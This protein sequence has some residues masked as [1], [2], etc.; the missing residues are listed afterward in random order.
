MSQQTSR[1]ARRV[2]ATTRAVPGRTDPDRLPA[3]MGQPRTRPHPSLRVGGPVR[4]LALLGAALG[5]V[6]AVGGCRLDPR[7]RPVIRGDVDPT[8]RAWPFAPAS[9]RIY[10]LTRLDR[11]ASGQ[12]VVIV[13][14]ETVD[15]W[16][17]FTKALGTLELR[18][19]AGDRALESWP[20]TLELSWPGIALSD[21]EENAAWYD[22]ASK[23]YRF[24]LGGLARSPRITDAAN[25]LLDRSQGA[26]TI[27][28]L[29][30]VAALTT[31]G[32][33]GRE[34]LLQDSYVIER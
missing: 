33:D 26:T 2:D 1:R 13:Y 6:L 14:M 16:G 18:V 7:I 30:V 20:E 31:A 23:M 28:R 3:Q 10:P 11:D 27:R 17:D 21:L 22:P 19:Y 15:R 25:E 29:R 34:I 4:I 5:S 24:T 32:P 9:V 8:G 12:P